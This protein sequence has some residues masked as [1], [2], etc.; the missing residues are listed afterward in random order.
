VNTSSFQNLSNRAHQLYQAGTYAEALDLVT[1]AFPH[2]PQEAWRLYFWRVCLESLT[3]QTERALDLLEEAVAAGHWYNKRQLRQDED[4]V[5]LQGLPRFEALA[6]ICLGRHAA[7]QAQAVPRLLALE[8]AGAPRPWPWLL[9]LHGHSSTAE[10]AAEHW[11]PAAG[12]GWLV[13]LAQSS[14]I[15]GPDHYGWDDW[16]RAR[17]EI[18]DHVTALG[19]RYALD[20]ECAVL[21]GFSMGGGLA[22]WLALTGAL[23]VRGFILVGAFVPDMDRMVS[24]MDQ[25]AGLGL[26]GYLIVG[27]EDEVCYQMSPTLV[28]HLRAAGIP[29]ELEVHPGMGHWVP[30]DFEKSLA[31]AFEFI[32]EA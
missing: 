30:P 13:A 17:G 12:M 31:R 19:D 3:G 6:Q 24:A 8:P 9:A 16:D 1:R 20:E 18:V 2:F 5:P 22:A 29:C 27:Q 4:L 28:G 23:P 32:L 7:A 15:V 25:A 21:C 10:V 14:Q 26:R 11:R